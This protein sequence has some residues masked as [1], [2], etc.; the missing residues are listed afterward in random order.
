VVGKGGDS[1]AD[2]DRL[3]HAGKLPVFHHPSQFFGNA[4]RV[5]RIGLRQDDPEFLAAV[6][7][8][9]VN[10]AQLLVEQR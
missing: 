3:R 7:A 4:D 2:G 9:H 8:H 5:R 6:T 10:F 1:G